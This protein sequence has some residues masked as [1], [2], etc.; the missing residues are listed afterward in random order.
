VW[1]PPSLAVEVGWPAR[2]AADP[3]SGVGGD[4]LDGAAEQG[5]DGQ[6]EAVDEILIG[7]TGHPCQLRMIDGTIPSSGYTFWESSQFFLG[8][9]IRVT[10][11][12]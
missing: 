6:P 11:I 7:Q 9:G 10:S 2:M 3:N 1:R 12:V 5:A 4:W 8:F